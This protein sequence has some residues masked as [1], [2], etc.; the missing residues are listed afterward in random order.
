MLISNVCFSNIRSNLIYESNLLC[1]LQVLPCKLCYDTHL[2]L[3]VFQ[4]LYAEFEMQGLE[5]DKLDTPKWQS[6]QQRMQTEE[7]ACVLTGADTG[8]NG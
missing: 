2:F 8:E 3:L 7:A 5:E 1:L 6:V 4:K